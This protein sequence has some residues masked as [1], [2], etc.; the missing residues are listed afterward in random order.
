MSSFSM[1]HKR[2]EG[3]VQVEVL[4]LRKTQPFGNQT[5]GSVITSRHSRSGREEERPCK[6]I[7]YHN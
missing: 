2:L 5:Q 4:R 1:R 6:K 3:E 7:G